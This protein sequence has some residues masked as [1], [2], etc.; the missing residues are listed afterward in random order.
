M[1]SP[2][3]DSEKL[4][5]S[6][7]TLGIPGTSIARYHRGEVTRIA[8]GVTN[9]ETQ[10]EVDE[11]TV[12]QIGSISKV[13]TAT[14]MYKYHNEGLVNLD[15]PVSEYL[16]DLLIDQQP[17][18][19]SLTVRTLLD[20]TSGIDGEFF[21]DFGEGEDAIARYVEACSKL[22]FVHQ[23]NQLRSYNSTAYSIAGRIIEVLTE[24]P[25]NEVLSRGLINPLGLD[26]TTYY[27]YETLRYRAAIGH[28]VEDGQPHP[29]KVLKLPFCLS[30]AGS[31]LTMTATDLLTFGRLHL[32]GGTLENGESYLSEDSVVDMRTPRTKLPPGEQEILIGWAG[33]ETT[34][35]KLIVA[36][37]SSGGQNSFLFF[38]PDHD[39]A[40][41]VLT[42]T[43][44]GASHLTLSLGLED[45]ELCTGA[46]VDIP[47]PPSPSDPVPTDLSIYEGTFTNPTRLAFKASGDLLEVTTTGVDGESGE[48]V[49]ITSHV[50]P[51]GG[52]YF[53]TLSEEGDAAGP[54]GEFL[55][56][57]GEDAPPS[58]FA[59]G[60][61]RV[62]G[63][64]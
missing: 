23:P 11:S 19:D 17:V 37:G 36:S 1:H 62:F 50:Q 15:S 45:L 30:P 5:N 22:S 2:L 63:R 27:D 40:C 18:P 57:D 25:F 55:F 21:E 43:G 26:S 38:L 6:L 60:G 64:S 32:N 53:V 39:Y 10:V 33:I 41:S 13:F 29:A 46:K 8:A 31:T 54:V 56:L 9:I 47:Q 61:T 7:E 14:L 16:P 35:G 20:Y 3:F 24:T 49:S 52:H 48:T 4:N 44:D 58:H 12:F 59:I 51:I 28:T 34:E 42:N